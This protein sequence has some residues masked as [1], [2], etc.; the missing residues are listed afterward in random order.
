MT[1]KFTR[2]GR[3]PANQGLHHR[4]QRFHPYCFTNEGAYANYF[5]FGPNFGVNEILSKLEQERYSKREA[6]RSLRIDC[7]TVSRE[8]KA[9]PAALESMLLQMYL[10]QFSVLPPANNKF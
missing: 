8:G 6:L 5:E 7:F 2:D 1:G 3:L 10:E 9:A 4:S